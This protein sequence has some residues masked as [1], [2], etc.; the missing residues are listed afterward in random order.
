MGKK[1]TVTVLGMQLQIFAHWLAVSFKIKTV[2][3]Q[4]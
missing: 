3:H 4:K 1:F 2:G